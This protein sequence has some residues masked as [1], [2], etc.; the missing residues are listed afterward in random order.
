LPSFL[1]EII[2]KTQIHFLKKKKEKEKE[3]IK[4][5]KK[6]GQEPFGGGFLETL[7]FTFSLLSRNGLS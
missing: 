2:E 3:K 7:D 5:I 4:T 1:T 6:G